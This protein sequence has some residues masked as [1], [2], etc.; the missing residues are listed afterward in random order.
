MKTLISKKYLW[1]LA[2]PLEL[3]VIFC[4]KIKLD[5]FFSDE[6]IIKS[7]LHR[8]V[9]E[10][11]D[12][13]N[14]RSFS[15][16]MCWLKLHDRRTINMLIADKYGVKQYVRAVLGRD[17]FPKTYGVYDKFDDIDFDK[18]PGKFIMKGTHDCGSYVICRDKSTFDIKKAEKRLNT[19]LGHNHYWYYR[20]W[21]YRYL[22]RRIIIEELLV[23]SSSSDL[24]DYKFFCFNGEPAF[25]YIKSHVEDISY[26]NFFNI[27][28]ES[29]DDME[30][31]SDPRN[32]VNPPI[33]RNL[34]EMVDIARKLAQ[35]FAHVRVDF[36]EVGDKIYVGELTLHSAGGR[37]IFTKCSYDL[38]FG[39]LIKTSV[40]EGRF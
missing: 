5:R 9:K 26:F 35:P 28:G 16:K 14:P 33:P 38:M 15:E 20:E 4:E 21:Q 31:E 37:F 23:D 2:N 30:L 29:I 13:K 1:Y 10:D 32:P 8:A 22:P 36:Y 3:F 17:C 7:Q 11:V 27:K 24:K 39:D 34:T 6:F 25:F 19:A 40:D 18:L 12:L